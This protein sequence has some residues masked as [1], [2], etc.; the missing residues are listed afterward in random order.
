MK[1][2]IVILRASCYFLLEIAKKTKFVETEDV[3]IKNSG[4]GNEESFLFF[5]LQR[6]MT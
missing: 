6:I 2:K 3:L 4:F 1:R 5:F